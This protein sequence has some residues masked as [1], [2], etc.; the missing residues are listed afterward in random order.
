MA[1]VILDANETYT[2]ASAST[3]F[4]AAGSN[5]TVKV[6]DGAAVTFGGD[7]ERVEFAGASTAFTYKATTTGVQVLKGTTVVAN[8]VN[9]QKLA[10]TDGSATVSVTFDPATASNVVKVGTQTVTATAAAPTFTPNNAA[11]EAS[12]LTAGS[13]STPTTGQSFSLTAGVDTKT[14]TAGNDSFDATN[15]TFSGLDNLD[16]GDGTDTLNIVNSGTTASNPLTMPVAVT[17][18]N[19]ETLNVASDNAVGTTTT[20]YDVSGFAGLTKAVVTA[21]GAAYLKAATTTDVTAT[22]AGAIVVD[23]GKTV[24]ATGTANVTVTGGLTSANVTTATSSAAV[25]IGDNANSATGVTTAITAATVK[26]GSDVLVADYDGA[27]TAASKGTLTTVTISETADTAVSLYGKALTNLNVGKQT[28]ATAIT[29]DQAGATADQAFKLTVADSGKTGT[30]AAV[31]TVTNN[32]ASSIAVTANGT[33][34]NIK[35]DSDASLLAVTAAGAGKLTL[36]LNS[37]GNTAVASF[38]GS[39]ATGDLTLSNVAAATVTLK[40]GAGAD[41]FTVTATTKAAVDAGAG[42]DTVTVGASQAAGTTINLG[43]GNDKLLKSGSG[44]IA[45][46]TTTATTVIDGG[47]GTDTLA[48]ALVGS[49]NIGVFKNFEVFDAVALGATLDTDLLVGNNTVTEFVASADV[50]TSAVLTNVA[51]GVGFRATGDMTTNALTLTQKTAGALTVTLDAD[52]TSTTAANDTNLRATATNATALKAVFGVDSGFVQTTSTLNDAAIALT[53]TKATA[54]EVVSGGTNA[55]NSLTYVYGTGTATPSGLLATVTVTGSQNL[56]LSFGDSTNDNNSAITSI[57][58]S[59]LTGKL[60]V[61]VS[62]LKLGAGLVKLG[63]AADTV[64]FAAARSNASASGT[65]ADQFQSVANFS[66]ASATAVS[67][68][69]STTDVAAAVAAADQLVFTSGVVANANTSTL[70]AT[71]SKG[72]LTFTGAGPATLD[73]ALVIA[74]DFA[75]SANE[76]L[77]FEFAGNTYVFVQ[78]A[79]HVVGTTAVTNA[80]AL[81]KLVGVTGVTNF[82][83]VATSGAGADH[84]FIV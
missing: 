46:S 16:G 67:T 7:V 72:V 28:T 35:L 84:F 25:K 13:S 15:A 30:G 12:T 41:T 62:D 23:G 37:T 26:G 31:V 61:D 43:A 1:K 17:V 74:D 55:T 38:D 48:L 29:V 71:L 65:T 8:V 49:A 57:D 80:D 59:A 14:G 36:D 20:S 82:V 44:A 34:N 24:T 5:E 69:A 66:K 3:I 39:A 68:T 42:N 19:I 75:E 51:A 47:D 22:A 27:T 9:N 83:E 76:A 53:G 81:I 78:G 10:F 56:T 32:T 2:V 6:L 60:S 40:T 70:A 77:A 58:A 45:A 54:L 63:S 50:S 64:T 33:D 73:A 79:T 4:G 21:G 52:S 11:G 18:K